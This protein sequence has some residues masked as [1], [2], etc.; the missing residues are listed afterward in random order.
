MPASF[1]VS[2]F[3]AWALFFAFFLAQAHAERALKGNPL[4]STLTITRVTEVSNLVGFFVGIAVLGYY[5]YKVAWYWP[6]VL[7]VAG[8]VVGAFIMGLLSTLIGDEALV[9]RSFIAWP[10]FALWAIL[11]IHGIPSRA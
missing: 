8:S 4:T 11:I 2:L 1:P 6:I 5:F 10:A 9:K 3:L 7:A